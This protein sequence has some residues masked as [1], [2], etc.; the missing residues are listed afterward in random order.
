MAM[1]FVECDDDDFITIEDFS[2]AI[3]NTILWSNN[4]HTLYACL[5]VLKALLILS[6]CIVLQHILKAG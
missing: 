3:T 5:N 4:S 2:Q 6:F 1:L